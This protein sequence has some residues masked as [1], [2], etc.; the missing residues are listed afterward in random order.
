MYEPVYVAK[1][2]TPQYDERFI[3]YGLTRNT[4]VTNVHRDVPIY[5]QI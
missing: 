1:S 3:G 5:K 4:Q 2:D